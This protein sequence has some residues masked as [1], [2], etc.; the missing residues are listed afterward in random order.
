MLRRMTVDVSSLDFGIGDRCSASMPCTSDV[1][2]FQA[3]YLW[4]FSGSADHQ[5]NAI[6]YGGRV[7][8]DTA[9][10]LLIGK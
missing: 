6:L 10:R 2:Y 4:R 3:F 1:S 8:L 5:D 9:M 7:L